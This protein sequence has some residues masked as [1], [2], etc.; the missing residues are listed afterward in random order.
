M[1]RREFISFLGGAAATWPLP[2]RAQ[3]QE[4]MRRIGWLVSGDPKSYRSALAAFRD[5][6][7]ALNY[8]EGQ[9]INIEY[10]WAEGN[11][12]QLP[13]LAKELVDLKV[14]I[15]LAGGS[16]GAQAALYTTS[17]I[18]IVNA[19][20]TDLVQ[21]GLV[22]SFARPGGNLTGFVAVEPSVAAKRLQMMLE[23][24]PE[25]RRAAILRY[26]NNVSANLEWEIVKKFAAANNIALTLYDA[27]D[28]EGLAKTL[29][30]IPQ[31]DP[32]I[33]VLLTNP[34]V[35]TYRKLIIDAVNR[36]RLASMY[37]DRAFVEDG[38]MISYGTDRLDTYRRAA[39]YVDKIFK[40][41]KPADLPIQMP[42]KFELVVNLKT[43]K[44]I[45]VTIPSSVLDRANEVIE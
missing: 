31:S 22:K 18:P 10:R 24:K 32:D 23:I 33:F 5:G 13:A 40:G 38:G 19:G 21:A 2:A 27:Y 7:L 43:A 39:E 6:L 25:K 34:F 42:T 37:T 45:G 8:V 11:L 17:V 26:P 1:R 15:I 14:D 28:L 30:T 20:A 16:N 12:A 41:A 4:R 9:N 29:T 36:F 35:F 3:Q 44:A